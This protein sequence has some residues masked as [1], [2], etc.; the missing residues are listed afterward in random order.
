[1]NKTNPK[2]KAQNP[3]QAPNPK[4]QK[5]KIRLFGIWF[6]GFV[7]IFEFG[8][9]GFV[10]R[11]LQAADYSQQGPFPLR[12]QHPVYLQTAQLLPARAQSLP[13]GVLEI[14][15]DQ[16]YSNIYERE[17]DLQSDINL[18]MEL[19]RLGVN[20][21]YGF[22]PGWEAGIE[23]PFLSFE[24]GFLDA[25]IQ[26]F[27]GLFGFPNGGRDQIPNG[28]YNYSVSED[29][30]EYR[31]AEQEF[32]LGD[33][34]LAVKHHFLE[35]E[36]PIPAV[37]WRFGLKLPSGDPDKG[38][39]SGEPG[40]GFG[41]A[42]DKSY[43]RFHGYLNLNLEVDSGNALLG[44]LTSSPY[45]DFT[46]A[47]EFSFSRRISGLVQLTGGSQRLKSTGL[48]TWD[49][50]PLDL[51]IGAAGDWNLGRSSKT[52]FWQL[53]FSEDVTAVGPSVDFT[54]FA[55]AGLRF[56]LRAKGLYKGDFLG[57]RSHFDE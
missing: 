2:S 15:L 51:V 13:R 53:A 7:L 5:E 26:D 42:L 34:S 9:L 14:R 56:P 18:D 23:I 39:G 46:L 47:G 44:D 32:S 4:F 36:G 8:I 20:A 3:K 37:A 49:G 28:I 19:Y 33:I 16:A 40:F 21:A 54:V 38:M 48:E 17:S 35:E 1:M 52:L 22:L 55:S 12:T 30:L 27:H 45:F 50:M 57:S 25:F 31:V 11:R 43:R 29:G 24:G 41:L 10:P 6:L